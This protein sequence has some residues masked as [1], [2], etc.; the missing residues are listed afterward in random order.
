MGF[1]Y[2]TIRRQSEQGGG[3]T[4]PVDER[5]WVDGAGQA[6][7]DGDPSA[8]FLLTAGNGR[9][10]TVAALEA[11]GVKVGKGGALTLPKRRPTGDNKQ[12]ARGQDKGGTT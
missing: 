1:E 10:V 7:A 11:A 2:N 8:A 6:V 5:L 4:V 3:K 12:A 9:R